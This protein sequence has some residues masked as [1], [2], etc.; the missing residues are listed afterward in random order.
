[1]TIQALLHQSPNFNANTR[2]AIGTINQANLRPSTGKWLPVTTDNSVLTSVSSA[3]LE[4]TMSG[5]MF[6][7]SQNANSYV[8]LFAEYEL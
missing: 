7:S 4:I 3:I 2:Y 8:Y 5:E 6:F 1:M